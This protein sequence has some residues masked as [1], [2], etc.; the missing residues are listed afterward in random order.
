MTP[1]STSPAGTPAAISNFNIAKSLIYVG[2]PMCSWCYGFGVPLSQLLSQLPG[3]PL[4]IVLGGLRAYNQEI[5]PA[6]LKAKLHH[7]W[8]EVTKRSGKPF[9]HGQFDRTDF[10]YDTEPAC[11]A[12]VTIRAYAP[13]HALAMYHAIQHAFYAQS[14]DVTQTQVLADVWQE[15][16]TSRSMRTGVFSRADFVEAFE[17]DALKSLT[18]EDFAVTQQWGIRGFPALIAVVDGHAELVAN[19]YMEAAAMLERVN[20]AFTRTGTSS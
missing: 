2:D 9:G 19:G 10:V 16:I 6:D 5:M 7:H 14:R 8:E 12:V 4:T 17:S 15:L 18:K 1:S 11:R 20:Q 3:V 13:E